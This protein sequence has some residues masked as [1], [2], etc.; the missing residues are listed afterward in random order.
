MATV[1]ATCSGRSTRNAGS[2]SMP[3]DTKNS[4][5]NASRSDRDSSAARRLNSDSRI[6][7]PAKKAPSPNDTLNSQAAAKAMQMAVAPGTAMRR[8]AGRSSSEKC[9][10][11]PDIGSITPISDSWAT[12]PPSPT[13]PGVAGPIAMPA[14]R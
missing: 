9:R 13:K 5:A 1:A 12:M 14:T 4:T 11:T 8:T 6:T 2:N 7:V 10:P 3:I